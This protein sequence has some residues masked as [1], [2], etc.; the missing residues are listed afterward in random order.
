M[1]PATDCEKVKN[2]DHYWSAKRLVTGPFGLIRA[3]C[4][5]A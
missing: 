4:R 3:A 2:V 1:C 5:T